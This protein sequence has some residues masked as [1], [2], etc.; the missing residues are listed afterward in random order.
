MLKQGPGCGRWSVVGGRGLCTSSSSSLLLRPFSAFLHLPSGT[1]EDEDVDAELRRHAVTAYLELATRPVLSDALV[2]VMAWVL[3][4]Y[5]PPFAGAERA[6]EVLAALMEKNL[7]VRGLQKGERG[8][9]MEGT[10]VGEGVRRCHRGWYGRQPRAA[11]LLTA[12]AP[13]H[14]PFFFILFVG[15]P[16]RARLCL[17]NLQAASTRH[18]I[19]QALMKTCAAMGQC[20]P[21]VLALVEKYCDSADVE[22]QQVRNL[23]PFPSRHGCFLKRTSDPR[24]GVAL[25]PG[26]AAACPV[27]AAA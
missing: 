15:H 17:C 14:S 9:G 19:L 2:A 20:P 13:T 22:L 12:C 11:R 16:S 3:G 24:S 23:P 4:E 18:E 21:S 8:R 5:G 10:A 7:K 1:G 26:T 27:F 6:T 25:S